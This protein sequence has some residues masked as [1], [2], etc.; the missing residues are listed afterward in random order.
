VDKMKNHVWVIE[1]S[2]HNNEGHV[3]WWPRIDEVF[4]SKKLCTDRMRELRR[5]RLTG[6]YRIKKYVSE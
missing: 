6:K 4:R 5:K 2:Y 3:F 1:N